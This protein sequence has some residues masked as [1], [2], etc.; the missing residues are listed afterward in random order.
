MKKM[1]FLLTFALLC[2]VNAAFA[3]VEPGEPKT[4]FADGDKVLITT[5]YTASGV[6]DNG[7]T[8]FISNSWNKPAVVEIE[9]PTVSEVYQMVAVG[10][11]FA[12]KNVRGGFYLA[13]PASLNT[14]DHYSTGDKTWSVGFKTTTELAQATAFDVMSAAAAG[15]ILEYDASK[16]DGREPDTE[17]VSF[18]V[19]MTDDF[20]EEVTLALN[21][22]GGV[23]MATYNDYA[24]WYTVKEA[25][26]V[27]NWV[28]DLGAL[29]NEVMSAAFVDGDMDGLRAFVGGTTPGS[30]PA[31]VVD[32]LYEKFF[33]ADTYYNEEMGEDD[34]ILAAH[35]NDL[36]AAWQAIIASE[37]Q[38]MVAGKYRIL[39]GTTNFLT[40]GYKAAMYAA[41]DGASWNKLDS[42]GTKYMWEITQVGQNA[43]GKKTWKIQNV[44]TKQYFN[45]VEW[46]SRVTMNDEFVNPVYIEALDKGGQFNIIM[47][48][49]NANKLHAANHGNGNNNSGNIVTWDGGAYSAS[50]WTFEAVTD[51]DIEAADQATKQAELNA[52]M[53]ELIATAA[54]KLAIA[55]SYIPDMST[56]LLTDVNQISSNADQNTLGSPD[57]GGIP[58]LIDGDSLTF[59]H[60]LWAYTI[61][62]AHY[63]QFELNDPVDAVA[64]SLTRRFAQNPW[65]WNNFPTIVV[66]SASN[67]GVNFTNV[68][69]AN[70]EFN[71]ENSTKNPTYTIPGVGLNGEYKHIRMTVTKQYTNNNANP[72]FTLGELQLHSC[73][74]DPECLYSSIPTAAPLDAAIAKALGIV[75]PTQADIDELQAAYDAYIAELPD[76][77]ALNAAITKATQLLE[78][79]AEGTSPGMFPEGTDASALEEEVANA[80]ALLESAPTKAQIDAQVVALNA[81]ID[82][83]Q[84]L[85]NGIKTDVWYYI[86]NAS[87]TDH[88]NWAMRATVDDEHPAGSNVTEINLV[89]TYEG[90]DLAKWRFIAL[91]DTAFVMQNKA[92]GLYMNAAGDGT[93]I[94]LYHMPAMIKASYLGATSFLLDGYRL[95]NAHINPLHGQNAGHVLVGWPATDLGSNSAW[96]IISTE[97]EIVMDEIPNATNTEKMVMGLPVF[98]TFPLPV[99]ITAEGD[100]SFYSICNTVAPNEDEPNGGIELIS[101]ENEEGILPAGVPFIAMWGMPADFKQERT[102]EDTLAVTWI[103]TNVGDNE[104]PTSPVVAEDSLV[105]GTYYGGNAPK[106]ATVLTYGEYDTYVTSDD[107]AADRDNDGWVTVE[108]GTQ[109][110]VNAFCL[111]SPW[112]PGWNSAYITTLKLQ[113][114]PVAEVSGDGDGEVFIPFNRPI[115]PVLTGIEVVEVNLYVANGDIYTTTGILVRKNS[116]S[117]VGLP[118]GLYI[119]NGKTVIVK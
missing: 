103:F 53:Q 62:E 31:A 19:T 25:V 17:D 95:D 113:N 16:H 9:V 107:P 20:G 70:T 98:R 82:A 60:S 40:R 117:T 115:S 119:V 83:L 102:P 28:D 104:V 7:K 110:G 94:K 33:A 27:E 69:T 66:I 2:C 22:V 78:T 45:T 116:T 91:G 87:E 1:Y 105:I 32:N 84:P 100:V 65:N 108:E 79:M 80:Q 35:Y 39:N 77:T 14:A 11:K 52:K 30:R 4:S 41:T 50:S 97:E 85:R 72:F 61:N 48:N 3:A 12:L 57:G 44:S 36:E 89:E 67:D 81:A 86:T 111:V 109:W 58:A 43:E 99:D 37:V 15:E 92:T 59:F 76:P 73:V 46:N 74:L 38:P 55:K 49:G 21:N 13:L 10:E 23:Y 5:T 93:K 6:L 112:N 68:A 8:R 34:V 106:D 88:A 71:E 24:T 118:K 114:L 56:K 42:L 90:D 51:A 75:T 54:E 96:N 26:E 29:L 63:L 18:L 101:L 64:I 47:T